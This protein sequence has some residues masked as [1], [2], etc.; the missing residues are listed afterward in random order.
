MPA[1]DDSDASRY[2]ELV[3]AIYDAA[4]EP[5][6]WS[7]VVERILPFVHA[8]SGI[9]FTPFDRIDSPGFYIPVNVSQDFLQL[10]ASRYQPHDPWAIA[11]REHDLA[12]T[13]NVMVGDDVVPRARLL[14]SPFYKEFLR[15]QDTSRV[16]VAWV[17]GGDEQPGVLNTALTVHRSVRSR[18]FSARSV[19]RMRLLIPHL[20]RALGVMFRLRDAELKIAVTRGALD[21]LATGV[22]LIGER[23]EVVFAN[24]AATSLLE[25]RDGLW[26][27]PGSSATLRL[28]AS[29]HEKTNEIDA[30]FGAALAPAAARL[31][32][33]SLGIRVPRPSGRAPLVLNVSTLPQSNGFDARSDRARVI[34][35]LSDSAAPAVVD[36]A[37]LRRLYALS[38]RE[39]RV[40]QELC[41]GRSLAEIATS[42]GTSEAT[43]R[44][45][46]QSAFAK[47][48]TG[49][50]AELVK[51]VLSLS[52]RLR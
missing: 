50:Q 51:L 12:R 5:Q 25:E 19:E 8:K 35:F 15:P 40:V 46:L 16:C 43:V 39:S 37:L 2:A 9:L 45:Q 52:S 7:G 21:R 32:H 28:V 48:G 23:R 26:L 17:F 1:R 47:T 36:T 13:G 30:A 33:F 3:G 41:A 29:G 44:S 22:L 38:E 31:P 27:G 42:L 49:R 4:L 14:A 24:R 34:A 20:S 10:Y 6:R 11:A 18:P